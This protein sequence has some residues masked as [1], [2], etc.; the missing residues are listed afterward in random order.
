MRCMKSAPAVILYKWQISTS[1]IKTSG[2]HTHILTN[3]ACTLICAHTCIHPQSSK[4]ICAFKE[5]WDVAVI[6]RQIIPAETPVWQRKA[7]NA[8]VKS[9]PRKWPQSKLEY[10]ERLWEAE[11]LRWNVWGFFK[12]RNL[13]LFVQTWV[14][15]MSMPLWGPGVIRMS[16]QWYIIIPPQNLKND[17]VP[18][19]HCS[20]AQLCQG[21][22][23]GVIKTPR[24]SL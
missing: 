1:N 22:K 14:P 24:L 19:L 16:A 8:R 2:M 20:S 15:I 7:P 21:G 17:T 10:F 4:V 18:K 6:D 11:H 9:Q 5:H 3:A 13:M 23:T 12:R